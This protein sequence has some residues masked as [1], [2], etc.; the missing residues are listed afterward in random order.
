MKHKKALLNG[1]KAAVSCGL[2]LLLYK[3]TP[4][5]AIR[6]V[7]AGID[8]RFMPFIAV[9]LFINTA[10]SALKW[11]IFLRADSVYITL[12]SL[13]VTYLIGSFYNL[14]LPSNIG[15]DSY[16]IFHIARKSREGVRSAASVFA[17]RLS[18][19]L[20]LVILSVFSSFFV[21]VHFRQPLFFI[22][23]FCILLLLLVLIVALAKK[24]PIRKVLSLTRLDRVATITRMT[25]KFFLSFDRYGSKRR[26]L[27]QVMLISFA[28]Q[29]SVIFIV[30]LLALSLGCTVSFVYFSAFVPLITLM[31]AIP[32]SIYGVG[33]RDMGYV[34]F[35]GWAGM[36]DVQTRSLALLFLAVTVAYSLLGGILYLAKIFLADPEKQVTNSGNNS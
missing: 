18:G 15:G 23:P 12:S 10:L 17:D 9:L 16:R 25:E 32:V 11:R 21:A 3:N 14:F 26:L 24:T 35:F 22:G 8:L 5:D 4:L 20:A 36:T 27:F 1:V 13:I 29:L 30:Y 19:F 6:A 7:F 31:E 34:F 33:I 2:L 28:F